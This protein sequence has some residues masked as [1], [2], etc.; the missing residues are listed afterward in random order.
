MMQTQAVGLGYANPNAVQTAAQVG[1]AKRKPTARPWVKRRLML[2]YAALIQPTDLAVSYLNS[3]GTKADLRESCYG[4]PFQYQ[5]RA[6]A[7]RSRLSC[8]C[9]R[10]RTATVRWANC[11]A[12]MACSL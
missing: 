7:S 2:D 11:G 6:S 4:E 9:D 1:L 8:N 5:T 12:S 3:I 10:S